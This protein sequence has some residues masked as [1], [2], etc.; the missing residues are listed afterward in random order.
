MGLT[1]VVEAHIADAQAAGPTHCQ[2]ITTVGSEPEAQQMAESAV[3]ARLAAC[4]QVYG[5]VSSTYW[6]EGEVSR[7]EEWQVAF[8]TT[9]GRYADLQTHIRDNHQYDVPEIL[10]LPVVAGHPPYLAWVSEETAV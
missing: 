3:L 6:W 8:K 7:V 9:T 4:A 10:C 5:P 1:Y 2:V